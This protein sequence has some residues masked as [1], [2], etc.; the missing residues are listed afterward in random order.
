[1][2]VQLVPAMMA[3]VRAKESPITVRAAIR[4]LKQHMVK[5]PIFEAASFRSEELFAAAI[6][7][8]RYLGLGSGFVHRKIPLLGMPMLQ[9]PAVEPEA[10]QCSI[11]FDAGPPTNCDL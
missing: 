2:V 4:V 6:G 7:T 5:E 1:M 8:T 3:V 10:Q 11:R 9:R